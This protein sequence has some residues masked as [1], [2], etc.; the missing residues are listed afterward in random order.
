MKP[1]V[2]VLS[3]QRRQRLPVYVLAPATA[4]R[5]VERNYSYGFSVRRAYELRRVL[6]EVA[7]YYVGR[8]TSHAKQS[9]GHVNVLYNDCLMPAHHTE[10]SRNLLHN[11]SSRL[12]TPA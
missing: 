12:S 6:S 7:F 3:T 9:D 4:A 5:L 10:D 2:I 1:W 11:S 8:L